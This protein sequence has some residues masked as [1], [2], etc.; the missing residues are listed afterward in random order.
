MPKPTEHFLE[1]RRIDSIEEV[2]G[3]ITQ[4]G[5]GVDGETRMVHL[6]LDAQDVADSPKVL[7][8]GHRFLQI[9]GWS[10][11][12]AAGAILALNALTGEQQWEFPLQSPPWSGVMATGGGLVF[13]ASN[14]GSFFALDAV[15]GQALWNFNTG[16]H[17]RTN[18]MG[19]AVDGHQRVAITGGRTLFVFGLE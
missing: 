6:N 2:F 14:E 10:G 7:L 17:I 18:P 1:G 11:D 16:A 9:H 8:R 4:F 3:F 13:G 19:F 5:M 12:D 15:S